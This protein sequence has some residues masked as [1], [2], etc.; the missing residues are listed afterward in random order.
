[1][2]EKFRV[3]I[4]CWVDL[5]VTP[6]L[7]KLLDDEDKDL[8]NADKNLRDYLKKELCKKGIVKVDRFNNWTLV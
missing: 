8:Y 5:D 1:M 6:E 4:D 2:Y 7:K 3:D